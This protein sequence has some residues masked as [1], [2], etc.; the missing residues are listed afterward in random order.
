MNLERPASAE[1]SLNNVVVMRPQDLPRSI[2]RLVIPV[3]LKASNSIKIKLSGS[4]LSSIKIEIRGLDHAAPVLT[5]QAP[6]EGQI[7]N[8]LSTSVSGSASERLSSAKAQLNN[9]PEIP[10]TLSSDGLSFSGN[11][12]TAQ[13]GAKVLTVTGYDLAGNP[14]T[15]SRNIM[16]HLNR[17]PTASLVLASSGSG[18]APVTVLFDA[19]SSSDP[20]GDQLTYRFDFDDGTVIT[21]SLPKVSHEFKDVGNYSVEVRVSDSSGD[22]Q[23]ASVNVAAIAAELPADPT[24]FAP[25]LSQTTP[26]SFDE[27]IR[28]LY[29]GPN[30]VQKE[31]AQDAIKAD[32]VA[33]VSGKVFDQDGQ[34]LSGVKVSSL[35]KESLGYTI[36]RAGGEFDIAV[37]SGG[38]T[39]LKFERNGYTHATRDIK[40]DVQSM[41]ALDDVLLVRRDL[42]VTAIINNSP[43]AQIA[44]GTT[45]TDQ[46]GTSTATILIPPSTTA[47]LELQN[48]SILNVDTLNIRMTEYTVGENGPKRMPAELPPQTGYTYALEISADEAIAK[49][50]DKVVFSKPVSFYVDNFLSLPAG[51]A[52]PL[53]YLNPK[54]GF[55]EAE[56]DGVVLSVLSHT[57][58]RADLNTGSGQQATAAELAVFGIDDV[59]LQKISTL[60]QPGQSFWRVRI[61]HFTS[62]DL[63]GNV[64]NDGTSQN[65]KVVYHKKNQKTECPGCVIDIVSGSMAET[66]ALPGTG[67]SLHYTTKRGGTR[68]DNAT[69][70]IN[71]LLGDVYP[72]TIN[73]IT[74]AWL[75]AGRNQSL[76]VRPAPNASATVTWDGLDRYGRQVY[77]EQEMR[78]TIIYNQSAGYWFRAYDPQNPSTWASPAPNFNFGNDY[79]FQDTLHEVQTFVVHY[80]KVRPPIDSATLWAVRGSA[81]GPRST[82]FR[83]QSLAI[84]FWAT[85]T[86]KTSKAFQSRGTLPVLAEALVS[87]AMGPGLN[88][89]VQWTP[90]TS[91]R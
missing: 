72:N 13:N 62:F 64:I 66:I 63:N 71:N 60:Y 43:E 74:V 51:I 54:T 87:D 82:S 47:T 48:G 76:E 1:I 85:V 79:Y 16:F 75:V 44:R 58:G 67:T 78:I 10:L 84:S 11:I 35:G 27:T 22:S 32:R 49:G 52:M 23:T 59:E 41:F 90:E 29:D 39:T 89:A 9:E 3:Q 20:D 70:T 53:G 24:P 57:N 12:T 14:G 37:N 46:N 88:C 50:A 91:P 21:S 5:L 55:W 26:Q 45:T 81:A 2:N 73:S 8:A 69:V 17:P 19:S 40:T 77:G 83:D 18:I 61:S 4:P 34:P 68:S 7:I 38:I 15:V 28:F 6:S 65:A 36:S 56:P 86:L 30:A 31:I 33:T 25:P 80:A 42:K